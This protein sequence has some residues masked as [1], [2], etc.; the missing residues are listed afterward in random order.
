MPEKIFDVS[1]IALA[2]M[3]YQSNALTF[4]VKYNNTIREILILNRK[5]KKKNELSKAKAISP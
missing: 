5:I 3:K 2:C 4:I 1:P